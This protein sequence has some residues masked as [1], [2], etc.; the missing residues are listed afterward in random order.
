MA[1][2]KPPRYSDTHL[3]EEAADAVRVF[4]DQRIAEGTKPYGELFGR[5]R[6]HV[7]SF[8]A[9]SRELRELNADLLLDHSGKINEEMLHV[10]RALTGPPTSQDDLRTL[11]RVANG[12]HGPVPA[13]RFAAHAIN[14]VHQALDP[15]RYPW[16]S[17]KRGPSNI[18]IDGAINWTAG[19]LATE[20]LRTDR[21]LS[22]STV[23]QDAVATALLAAGYEPVERRSIN[24]IDDLDPGTFTAE[25]RVI[26]TKCDVPV[27]LRDKRL[28]TIEC[29]V[30]NTAVNSY[31]RLI[32]E[33]GGK[34]R[35]WVRQLGVAGVVPAA[36][37]SGVY[38][39]QNL[40]SAQNDFGMFL[41]FQ[42]DLEPLVSF[43]KA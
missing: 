19:L 33:A 7:R 41:I 2:K 4:V 42:H 38:N 25:S 43:V 12:D 27:R 3:A 20:R 9:K 22:A 40:S 16:I 13:D 15:N 39:P 35:E 24:S 23:Q 17:L 11:V 21:R 14:I 31:K 26:G 10:A 30:S 6:L 1:G 18:E 36:V 34:A 29:K 37:L 28:M 5:Y 8:F 32:H